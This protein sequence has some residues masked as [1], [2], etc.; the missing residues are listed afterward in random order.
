MMK[1]VDRLLRRRDVE[2]LIAKSR[3]WIYSVIDPKSRYYDPDFPKP[4]RL[5]GNSVAWVETEIQ[6]WVSTRI[7]CRDNQEQ[8]EGV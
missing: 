5:G 2:A 1:T 6:A 4:I 8:G 3:S 7:A